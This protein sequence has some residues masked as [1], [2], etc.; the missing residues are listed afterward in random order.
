MARGLSLVGLLALLLVGPAHAADDGAFKQGALGGRAYRLYVPQRAA[1][2]PLPLVVALHGCFQ[3][4]EDFAVGTRL[5]AAAERR[6]LL[7]LYPAQRPR[8][9]AS[10]C[11]N[12]FE[13]EHQARVGGGETAEILALVA[14]VQRTH[15]VEPGRVVALGLS[16][17]AFMAVNLLCAA[18]DLVAGVGAVAG[19][20]YRCGLGW[21]GALA[22]MRGFKLDGAAAAAAC[23]AASGRRT[24]ALRASLWQ[25]ALDT[26]VAPA[27]L[28][29][30]ETMFAR[31]AGVSSGVTERQDGVLHSLYRDAEGRGVVETWL[32]PDLG[33]AWSG[34]DPR[35]THTAPWGPNATDLMLDFLFGRGA[36]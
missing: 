30:L 27:N 36:R 8:D 6:G 9:N 18:P 12:W 1:A 4:P 14:E 16:A 32:V 35:G 28:T 20:P 5:N 7:V 22:C 34:G 13:R 29:A 2:G 31:L 24:L 11:W 19:G 17:G 21:D 26:F 3:T 15:A 25:G 10:R 33:H 23:L